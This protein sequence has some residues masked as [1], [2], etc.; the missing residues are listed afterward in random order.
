MGTLLVGIKCV[1]V[2]RYILRTHLSLTFL[3]K[4]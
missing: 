3:N 4:N 1:E 2:A